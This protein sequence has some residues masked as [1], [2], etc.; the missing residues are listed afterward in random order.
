MRTE[1]QNAIE[2]LKELL[3]LSSQGLPLDKRLKELEEK[4]KNELKPDEVNLLRLKNEARP[5][6]MTSLKVMIEDLDGY[7]VTKKGSTFFNFTKPL[8]HDL[9][10][11]FRCEINSYGHIGDVF[12]AHQFIR[13]IPSALDAK[14]RSVRRPAYIVLLIQGIQDS[15]SRPLE[16]NPNFSA[17]LCIGFEQKGLSETVVG[18]KKRD[19]RLRKLYHLLSDHLGE[20][21]DRMLTRRS[22]DEPD[23]TGGKISSR[24]A[25]CCSIGF[26]Y[27]IEKMPTMDEFK[28]DF[29]TLMDI[30][31][32]AD[33]ETTDFDDVIEIDDSGGEQPLIP[34]GLDSPT[35]DSLLNKIFAY[36]N[37]VLEGVAGT[38]KSYTFQDLEKFFTETMRVVFHP[39]TSY[40]DFVEGIRPRGNEF[41]VQDGTFLEFAKRAANA[42]PDQNFLFVIDEINRANVSKVL[43]DLLLVMEPSKRMP[44]EDARKVLW[45]NDTT[46]PG[47]KAELQIE[48]M[49]PETNLPYRQL[50]AVPDNLYILGTMNTTDRSVGTIDLALRRRFVFH[51]VEPLE[52]TTLKQLLKRN[53]S[54]ENH[55]DYSSD[56]DQW[57][58]I[59][60]HLRE[61]VG[62][63]ALIGHSYFFEDLSARNRPYLSNSVELNIWQDQ[64][65]P[66]LAEVLLAFN[67]MDEVDHFKQTSYGGF[68]LNV[69]GT[70]F[71]RY[72]IVSPYQ[73]P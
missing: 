71:D 66:Q 34:R 46:V 73:A 70:G 8:P 33:L 12:T 2:S 57:S 27:S 41:K 62:V 23:F 61:K 37:V 64:L 40:E 49:H 43:G 65:L 3:N 31:E 52:P 51:R 54:S 26:Q 14:D 38:G 50:L 18:N 42:E 56:V 24:Y 60:K 45:D 32:K 47:D 67:A 4:S 17:F 29:V 44:K 9:K 35:D 21:S 28:K 19:V 11:K 30:Y 48:R 6:L 39:S 15:E 68:T 36:R 16:A 25:S 22:L 5:H 1:P 55:Y 69:Q 72:P 20:S 7:E 58:L 10:A 53:Q 13:F 63:D 59:N